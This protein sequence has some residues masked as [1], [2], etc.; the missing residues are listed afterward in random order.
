MITCLVVDDEPLARRKLTGL[1][2]GVDWISCVGEASDGVSAVRLI[3]TRRPDLVFLDIRMPGLSGIQVLERVRHQPGVVFTTAFDDYAVA[4][5]ELLALDYLLKP[6]AAERFNRTLARI[7]ETMARDRSL[8][9]AE[10]AAT[11]LGTAPL[12][13]V[14]VRASRGLI[15]M[16]LS[17]VERIEGDDDYSALYAGG[18]RYLLSRRLGDLEARLAPSRFVR[19]HRSHILNLDHVSAI[20]RLDGGRAEITMRSGA[21]VTSSRNRSAALRDA[22]EAQRG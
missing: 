3:D 4:A 9:V 16:P 17:E 5:F 22:I 19:V 21:K 18:R 1:L 12:T 10:R 6:F 11:A 2:A 14:F 7:R 13:R 8:G 15:S 20:R